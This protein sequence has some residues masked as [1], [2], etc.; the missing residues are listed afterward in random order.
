MSKELARWNSSMI[1]QSQKLLRTFTVT[2]IGGFA[3][4]GIQFQK[5]P[6]GL[7]LIPIDAT[8]LICCA[9]PDVW[10]SANMG[11]WL[12]RLTSGIKQLLMAE[13]CRNWWCLFLMIK[14]TV[15]SSLHAC[16]IVLKNALKHICA[17][18]NILLNNNNRKGN[19]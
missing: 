2:L 17:L 5:S 13:D 14:R 11:W 12:N 10:R 4:P 15:I 18:N 8:Y 7:S 16:Y 1:T 3:V 6:F 19:S 9:L